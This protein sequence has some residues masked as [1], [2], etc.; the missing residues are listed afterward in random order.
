MDLKRF[1]MKKKHYALS[2]FQFRS[3][4]LT[5]GGIGIFGSC[6]FGYFL[7]RFF[8][9]Y[10]KRLRFLGFSVHCGYGFRAI[11]LAVLDDFFF[12]LQFLI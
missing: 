3:Q 1:G 10:A 7:D 6:C 4:T 9:F 2:I 11:F 8:G 5:K 12:G